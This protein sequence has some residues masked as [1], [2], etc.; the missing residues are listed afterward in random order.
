MI[1]SDF[2]SAD[3]VIENSQQ[4]HAES[5][6]DGQLIVTSY[7]DIVLGQHWLQ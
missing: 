7:G 3:D 4:N 6:S 1:I 5:L 2:V